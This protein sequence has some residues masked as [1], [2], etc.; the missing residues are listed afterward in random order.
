MAAALSRLHKP[1]E[2]LTV[3][4]TAVP[5]YLD[6]AGLL[7]LRVFL[8]RSVME[9]FLG[10][11]SQSVTR[12][13]YPQT[14]DS[15]RSFC[16]RRHRRRCSP[17]CLADESGA[18]VM[19]AVTRSDLESF[20]QRGYTILRRAFSNSRIDS[21]VAA[22]E[23]TIDRALAGSCELTWIDREQR[24]PARTEHLLHPGKYQ[25]A[26]G[27]WLDEDLA[28]Q[29]EALLSGAARHSLFGM[30]AAG[31][32]Q[33]YLQKWHRDLGK[34]GAPDEAE[35]LE[36]QHGRLVQFN[37]PLAAGDRYLHIVPSSHGRPSTAAEIAAS[38][39]TGGDMPEALVVELEPGDIVYYNAN[40]W[41]R[42]WNPEGAKRW[43]MHCA[44]C[45][46]DTKVMSHEYGQRLAMLQSG[47]LER[48]T[49]LTRRYVERYLDRYP[50]KDPPSVFDL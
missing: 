2:V 30:L 22:V 5:V 41:H 45:S 36:R 12:V 3:G 11:G 31:G 19:A 37:A 10:G 43:T 15:C 1:V 16:R 27:E 50:E 20:N 40:L 21:L 49:P 28:P 34:P 25:P 8:D 6:E 47:H 29:I 38:Q 35:Y 14:E 46:A 42:G 32:G 24:L 33:P 23:T 26:Y 9:V 17:R 7:R 4:N 44:F 39:N 13:I 48:M 18:F